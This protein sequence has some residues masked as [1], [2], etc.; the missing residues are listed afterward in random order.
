MTSYVDEA[1]DARQK[2]IRTQKKSIKASEMLKE[3][4]LIRFFLCSCIWIAISKHTSSALDFS[5]FISCEPRKNIND[6]SI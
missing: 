2:E 4:I 3:M 1:E 6:I 5:Q